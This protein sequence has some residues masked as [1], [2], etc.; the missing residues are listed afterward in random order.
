VLI[1]GFANNASYYNISIENR[2]IELKSNNQ[3][4]T[5]R[6]SSNLYLTQDD[7]KASI[8][9]GIDTL[10]DAYKAR[11]IVVDKNFKIIKDSFNI[12]TGKYS[13]ANDTIKAYKGESTNVYD[14]EKEYISQAFPIYSNADEKIIDGVLLVRASTSDIKQLVD[15]N[16]NRLIVFNLIILL[17][18]V[19]LS[20][21]LAGLIEKPF[22]SLLNSLNKIS[23]GNIDTKIEENSYTVTQKISQNINSTME[24]LKTVDKSRDDFVANVSHEL[25]TPITSIRVL[26][27]SIMSMEDAP[28]ELYKEFMSDIS[29]EI[30]RESKIIDDL[31]S[32]VKMDKAGTVLNT[33]E[34]DINLLIKQ[35]LKRLR[36]IATA[37][38]V[39]IIYET[40]RE[41]KA[42]V[43]ETKLSL[44]ITN[45]VENA[46]KYN[47]ENGSVKVTLDA[48]HKFFYI[49]VIDTGIG[50]P[51]SE[52]E[53]IFE[54]F[55]RVD[56]A[57]SRSTGGTGLGLAITKNI[58]LKHKGIIKVSSKE[59]EG[60]TFTVRIPL[61]YIVENSIE[62]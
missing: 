18:V 5:N 50:M 29:N 30:D 41:V 49:K 54:R 28:K 25:K 22:I 16:I 12:A 26:A 4:L 61:N 27:D 58:I 35:I 42:E 37:K 47:K 51:E 31:L 24:K 33:E 21:Y 23:D 56:K 53:S 43:D 20:I 17:S 36:P 52:Y 59:E 62:K 57:R 19:M 10:A 8:D 45:L 11:I 15:A 6:I 9:A 44:A 34:V 32:L 39:D 38:K 48:D 46:I 55:Y 1:Y 60:S 40:V 2:K 3:I 13:V 14:N 7:N